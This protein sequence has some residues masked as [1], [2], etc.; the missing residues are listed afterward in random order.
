MMALYLINYRDM[1]DIGCTHATINAIEGKARDEADRKHEDEQPARTRALECIW[2]GGQLCSNKEKEGDRACGE[3]Q[4]GRLGPIVADIKRATEDCPSGGCQQRSCSK[5]GK[6]A[7]GPWRLA[8]SKGNRTEGKKQQ[9]AGNAKA[10]QGAS[11]LPT[12]CAL[13]L[14]F[15]RDTTSALVNEASDQPLGRVW[16]PSRLRHESNL[17][18]CRKVGLR[19][20]DLPYL[21]R[22][23]TEACN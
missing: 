12:S 3:T 8:P 5:D 14:E 23:A 2:S 11:G 9:R 19:I 20:E 16:P 15:L 18:I 17:F 1:C 7:R 13:L 10:R 22:H 6:I 4:Q 21:S